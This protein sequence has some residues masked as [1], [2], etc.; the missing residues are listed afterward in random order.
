MQL[1]RKRVYVYLQKAYVYNCMR[2][3]QILEDSHSYTPI[4]H[5]CIRLSHIWPKQHT[6]ATQRLYAKNKLYYIKKQLKTNATPSF[7]SDVRFKHACSFA[8]IYSSCALYQRHGTWTAWRLHALTGPTAE[9]LRPLQNKSSNP[10]IIKHL[11]N[12]SHNH[13]ASVRV[14]ALLLR[15]IFVAYG[16]K[17]YARPDNILWAICSRAESTSKAYCASGR[18]RLLRPWILSADIRRN[19]HRTLI[20]WCH[21]RIF[22]SVAE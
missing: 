2:W 19:G 12:S 14:A 15:E 7:Y 18:I 3:L 4:H 11:S 22:G 21:D 9:G 8:A 10:N 17:N 16:I 6:N 1:N 20:S 5:T 13:A